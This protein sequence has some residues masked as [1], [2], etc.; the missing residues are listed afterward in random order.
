V[1]VRK[2]AQKTNAQQT[3]KNLLL[4]EGTQVNTKPELEILADDVKCAHGATIGQ[5]EEEAIFYL[6]SRG[7]G[8]TTARSLLTYGF[9]REV[10][11]QIRVPEFAAQLDSAITNRLQLLVRECL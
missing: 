7:I 9:A 11:E 3:N 2:D 5:L 10:I 1:N 8:E 4:C 6:K